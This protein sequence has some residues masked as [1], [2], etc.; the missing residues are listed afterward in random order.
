MAKN[1]GCAFYGV[2]SNGARVGCSLCS[3]VLVKLGCFAVALALKEFEC[4]EVLQAAA[5]EAAADSDHDAHTFL[6]TSEAR[7]FEGLHCVVAL[8][9]AAA[10]V[11]ANFYLIAL[12]CLDTSAA[13]AFEFVSWVLS[14]QG[15]AAPAAALFEGSSCKHFLEH[16]FESC[17]IFSGI[18]L[19]VLWRCHEVNSSL[20]HK[21]AKN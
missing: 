5:A 11:A 10:R 12:S 7:V 4:Q 21:S 17:W 1:A 19:L 14:L 2:P 9:V 6:V 16:M 15:A 8:Q 18:V 3:G 20:R 13:Q